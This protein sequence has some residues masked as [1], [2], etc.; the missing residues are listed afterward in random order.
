MFLKKSTRKSTGRTQL[1]IVE[2]YY[3]KETKTSRT[4][5]IRTIGYLD[6]L[7]K[8]YD[9]PIGHFEEVVRKMSE[10]KQAAQAPIILEFQ[11]GASLPVETDNR[12]N[13]GY[14][15]VS[16]LYHDLGINEFFAN[17]QRMTAAE[18]NLNSVFRALVFSRIICPDSKKASFEGL[19]QFFDKC[20][21]SLDD[22]YRS[23]D[24]FS[25]YQADLQLWMHEHLRQNYGRDTSLV[26][27]DV[28]NYYFEIDEEDEMKRRGV[29]KEHRKDPIV[30]MG[31]F[32]DTNGLPISY[33]LF[34]GNT[35]D[36]QTLIPMM[37]KLQDDYNLGRVIVVADRGMITGDNIAQIIL[38]KNGYVLSYSIRGSDQAF[39]DYVLDEKDYRRKEDDPE[40]FKIKSRQADRFIHVTNPL[41][42]KKKKV[43]VE[44]KQ[45]V[46]YSPAYAKKAKYEREKLLEKSRDMIRNPEK[47][48]RAT[49]YGAAKYV[50]NAVFDKSTGEIVIESGTRLSLDQEL[51]DEEA[52]YDGYYAIVTSEYKKNDYEIIDIYRGLWEIEE[53]FGI[54]KSELETRPVYVKTIEHV[55]AHFL[56][57]FTALLLMKLME[58]RI[59]RKYAVQT[60]VESLRKCGC[61]LMD[62]NIYLFDYYD[63]V[64]KTLGE[65]LGITFGL[66]T[67]T[68]QEIKKQLAVT[69]KAIPNNKPPLGATDCKSRRRA[70]NTAKKERKNN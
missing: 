15:A 23:L 1:S 16:A 65:N 25:K 33:G 35:H 38:D 18:Y 50:K 54:T 9:D 24:F 63:D 12:K 49:G 52:K 66:Q 64:L 51:I 26:F 32:M 57:C 61:S 46:F 14:L 56:I 44:E 45:V 27:Y 40:G 39:K 10:E 4:R 41:T 11:K 8:E 68:L 19:R 34:S 69:K 70:E 2:G 22:V 53:N 48:T 43:P 36:S 6:E 13:Y 60:I 31:L 21:F 5:T 3:D 20:D 59:D 29:S 67:M 30:Q 62:R 37:G 17:R 55:K 58:Y 47:Y 28:T 42:D 7:L